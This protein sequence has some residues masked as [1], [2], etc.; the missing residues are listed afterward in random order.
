MIVAQAGRHFVPNNLTDSQR[1]YITYADSFRARANKEAAPVRAAS[2]RHCITWLPWSCDSIAADTDPGLHSGGPATRREPWT[3]SL[4]LASGGHRHKH[5]TPPAWVLIVPAT[6]AVDAI[7]IKYTRRNVLLLYI[8]AYC[9]L[10]A[11]TGPLHCRSSG[12]PRGPCPLPISLSL[13]IN[14]GFCE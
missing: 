6:H 11:L 7:L 5:C 1:Q 9:R 3:L 10:V 12:E 13:N 4:S 14:G 8:L 2:T